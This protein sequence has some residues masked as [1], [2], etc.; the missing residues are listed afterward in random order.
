LLAGRR[1]AQTQTRT[2]QPA[3]RSLLSKRF[4]NGPYV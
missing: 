4:P 3:G 1:S 2:W